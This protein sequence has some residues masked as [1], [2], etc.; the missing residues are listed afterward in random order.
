M[1]LCGYRV[2]TQ[3]KKLLVYIFPNNYSLYIIVLIIIL[4]ARKKF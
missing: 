3:I 2:A 1:K 4:V